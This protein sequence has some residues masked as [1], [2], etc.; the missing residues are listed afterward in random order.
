MEV[1]A[2]VDKQREYFLSGVTKSIAFRKDMLKKLLYQIKRYEKPIYTALK[3]D[4]GKS[5]AE[6][7]LT[8]LSQVYAELRLAIKQV[9]QWAKPRRKAPSL[10]TFP[11]S[12]WIYQE[13][14]GVVMILAPWNYPV[15][16]TLIPLIGAMAAGNCVLIKG[17]RSSFHTSKLLEHIITMTYPE[18]YIRCLP[19][20]TNYDDL[21]TAP[22][23]KIFFTGNP[24]V[25]RTVMAK[26]AEELT[27]VTL[28]LGGKSPALVLKD[29]DLRL[30]VKRIA[31]GK[32][33]NAGQTC[34]APDYVLVDRRIRAEFIMLLQAEIRLRYPNPL[35]NDLYPKIINQKHYHRLMGLLP[36]SGVWGGQGKESA[37]K[38]EPTLLTQASFD[39][40]AM[41]EE[42]FG[43]ILPII[44]Y[45]DLKEVVAR[46]QRLPKPLG[47]YLFTKNR[48]KAEELL[49][50][51]SFGGGC[52]NDVLL[53]VGN[54]RL[55]FGGVGNSGMGSYH[56]Q[57][58]FAAFSHSKSLVKQLAS[59]DLP[60][61]Y[62]PYGQKKL[63][64][65]K[66]LM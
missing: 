25:A 43:P 54:Y 1:K 15:N 5:Q 30:A 44:A 50:Q 18:N 16:L 57:A 31:W 10:A 22:L 36:E 24:K 3:L 19:A 6:A 37:L 21:F 52:I 17:S 55:P 35:E 2:V 39:D 58:S 64:L 4:L 34:L 45:G 9:G 48:R 60:L 49:G 14:L 40:A 41:Q 42:I 11:A 12:S 65:F 8:E 63:N 62:G 7:Y 29:A 61:R 47:T 46:L 38:M 33:L 59:W 56:G 23:D 27:P 26:A 53:Q 66:K 28:E 13:P 20:D 51:L 32:F